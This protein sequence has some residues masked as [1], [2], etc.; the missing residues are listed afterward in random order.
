MIEG[1]NSISPD[2]TIPQCKSQLTRKECCDEVPSGSC[3]KGCPMDDFTNEI[4][5]HPKQVVGLIMKNTMMM[6]GDYTIHDMT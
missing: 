4:C 1:I 3:V 5:V 2:D 6:V